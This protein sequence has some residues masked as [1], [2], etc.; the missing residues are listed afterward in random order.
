MVS[1]QN[2]H[3][4]RYARRAQ[5]NASEAS[6]LCTDFT[7]PITVFIVGVKNNVGAELTWPTLFSFM[8][9]IWIFSVHKSG[10][11]APPLH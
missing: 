2:F 10:L 3:V 6:L 9:V 5:R 11:K 4:L 1:T 7:T 8:I